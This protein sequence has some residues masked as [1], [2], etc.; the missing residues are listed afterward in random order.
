M[1]KKMNKGLRVTITLFFAITAGSSLYAQTAAEDMAKKFQNPLATIR[2]IM[3]DNDVLINYDGSPSKVLFQ[4]QPVYAVDFPEA[5]FSLVNRAVLPFGGSPWGLSDMILQ[6][7]FAPYVKGGWKWGLGPQFSL[8]TRTANGGGPGWG[9]GAAFV[10]VGDI[11]P[12]GFTGLA[13]QHFSFDGVVSFM[14]IQPMFVYSILAGGSVVNIMYGGT[15]LVNWKASSD[16]VT[17]PLGIQAGMTFVT[18]NGT[19]L[20]WSV[21]PYWNVL[22]QTGAPDMVVKFALSVIFP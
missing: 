8:K 22:K 2:G 13:S 6:F 5:E 15:T 10:I 14:Q 20:D 17:L 16:M 12:V 4:L 11:G 3:T 21:G 18:G 1:R 19:G 9:A 7:M